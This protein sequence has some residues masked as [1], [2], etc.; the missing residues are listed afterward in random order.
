MFRM[1]R[2][3]AALAMALLIP[4]VALAQAA[5]ATTNLSVPIALF[6]Y[7]PCADGGAGEGIL[8]TGDLHILVHL[9]MDSRGGFHAKTHYQPQ[10]LSGVGL[11]TGDT[12]QG[13]GVTQD[14]FYVD[15]SDG[16]PFEYTFVNN[17]RMIGQGP[18]NN[19]SVH[20]N[21]HITVD[22]NGNL[23]AWVD[24]FSATCK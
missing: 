3:M 1:R 15:G 4:G 24:N 9:T 21:V 13:T 16:A 19:Y 17:F 6:T 7:V 5:T 23:R 18:G 8:L 12:Y 11:V 22:A 10:G 2:L 14:Q 20:Q